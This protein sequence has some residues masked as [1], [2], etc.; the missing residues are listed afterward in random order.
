MADEIAVTESLPKTRGPKLSAEK[1]LPTVGAEQLVRI[2]KGYAVASS[3]GQ[4]QVNY[5]DVASATGLNPTVVS[6]NNTFLLESEIITSPKYG[7][8]LPSEEAV[9]FARESAWAEENA[10]SHLRRIALKTWYGQVAVQNFAT[11][12]SLSRDE[13]RR[14]LGIKCGATEA[15]AKALNY[16]VDFLI[17]LGVVVE[18]GNDL[19]Q[20]GNTDE[21]GKSAAF[22]QNPQPTS[23]DAV[24]SPTPEH[25]VTATSKSQN[26]SVVLNLNLNVRIEDLTLEN[27][28]RVR[29]WVESIT[30]SV[31]S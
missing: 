27:A 11:R 16:V 31:R 26:I 8:Y 7:Y 15:D 3:G 9:R 24:S 23:V 2:I 17:Y 30:K 20:R 6:G 28:E 1:A 12:V 19:L 22:L 10:K 4:S 21:L 14:V 13:L 5:K 29:D 18:D 25:E